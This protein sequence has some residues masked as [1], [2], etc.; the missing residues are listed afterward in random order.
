MRRETMQE[1]EE[2]VVLEAIFNHTHNL[3]AY[4][5]TEYNFIRVNRAYALADN[6]DVDYFKGKN[7]FDLYPNKENEIIFQE[8][9]KS[10]KARFEL[11]K[12]FEYDKHPER[13]R[14]Y[15]DWNLVPL[16]SKTGKVF[17]LI[18]T[19]QNVTEHM[20]ALE[21]L[22]E[23]ETKYKQLFKEAPI[24][25]RE[26]DL[27]VLLNHVNHLKAKGIENIYEY[28]SSNPTEISKCAEMIIDVR[29]NDAALKFFNVKSLKEYLEIRMDI[30]NSRDLETQLKITKIYLQLISG[31]KTIEIPRILTLIGKEITS[32]QRAIVVPGSEETLSQVLVANVDLT[33]FLKAEKQQYEL[34]KALNETEEKYRLLVENIPAVTWIS[35]EDGK[36]S[37]ISSNVEQVYGFTQEEIITSGN[38]LWFG[39]IHPDDVNQVKEAYRMLFEKEKKYDI[40]YRIKRKDGQWIWLHD[41]A[42]ATYEEDGILYGYGIFTDVTDRKEAEIARR[43]LELRRTEFITLTT[44]ELR[45]PLTILKGYINFFKKHYGEFTEED[46]ERGFFITEKNVKRLETLITGVSEL[47]RIE[48]GIFYVETELIEINSFLNEKI[49]AYQ[50]LLEDQFTYINPTKEESCFIEADPERLAQV[51]D[52]IIQNAIRHTSESSR[53]IL[54]EIETQMSDYVKIMIQD[55]GAGISSKN[56]NKIF[57][58]FVSI[59]TKYSVQ[60]T[61]IGLYLSKSIIEKLNG[62]IYV[63]SE[64]LDQGCTFT[65]ELPKSNEENSAK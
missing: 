50:D 14:S 49:L 64:G 43:D 23:S 35:S 55:N 56:I 30:F 34:A 62:R 18:L 5:D 3:I 28:F 8:V 37:F 26:I 47:T 58:P 63:K 61:G 15:W 36:T 25:I 45:T 27:S 9:V 53:E 42:I 44:H 17:G 54:V 51:I 46:L 21:K 4:L 57:E 32:Y 29:M 11:A 65:I 1:D 7:H 24:P 6:R 40:E 59:P 39:R 33:E 41:M 16:K 2:K 10:G 22:T 12:P 60:G 31:K 20:E 13:G 38:D 52:N 48:K 19:L